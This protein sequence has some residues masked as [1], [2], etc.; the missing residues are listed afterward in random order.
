MKNLKRAAA[1]ILILGG[2]FGLAVAVL[3]LLNPLGAKLREVGDP[4]GAPVSTGEGLLVIGLHLVLIAA[5]AW[6]AVA[7][8]REDE[9][10]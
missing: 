10:G 1:C 9:S 7:V 5:G 4:L 8:R 3:A 2:G 6:L